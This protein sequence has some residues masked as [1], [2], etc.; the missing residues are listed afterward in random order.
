MARGGPGGFG[1][2]A[3]GFRD[4]DRSEPLVAPRADGNSAADPVGG[5]ASLLGRNRAGDEDA[6]GR[7]SALINEDRPAL[8]VR[9]MRRERLD[10]TRQPADLANEVSDRL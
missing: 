6:D 10:H 4:R 1:S 3:R 8:A 2:A 9:R 7:L 5:A